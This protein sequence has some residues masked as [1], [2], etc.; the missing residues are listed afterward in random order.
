MVV[1]NKFVSYLSRVSLHAKHESAENTE[2][3]SENQQA[4]I[5]V[6]LLTPFFI[7]FIIHYEALT[8]T[9]GLTHPVMLLVLLPRRRDPGRDLVRCT[10]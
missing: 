8:T 4:I 1:L 5:R 2:L 7:Y 10:G 3:S 6:V 9:S